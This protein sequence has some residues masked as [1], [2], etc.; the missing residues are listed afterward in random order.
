M[1]RV[2]IVGLFFLALMYTTYLGRALVVP[3]L[4]AVL[5]NFLLSP[6]VRWLAARR[7]PRPLSAALLLLAL[8]GIVGGSSLALA[9]PAAEWMGRAPQAMQKARGTLEALRLRLR[10]AQDVA[11]RIEDATT[12]GDDKA[13]A[14]VSVAGPSLGARVFGSTTALLG[15][16]LTVLFL[17]FFLLAPGDVFL[18]KLVG[19]LPTRQDKATARQISLETEQQI[20]RYMVTVT[21]VNIALA[22][23]TAGTMAVLGLPN[24]ILWGVVAGFLNFVPYVGALATLAVLFMVSLVTFDTLAQAIVPPLAFFV[25]NMIESNLLTPKVLEHWLSLNAV[26]NFVGVLFFWTIL[27]LPGALLAVPILVVCK[28]LC[29][30]VESLKPFGAFLGK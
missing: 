21:L 24:P 20:S 11:T 30:H 1:V 9:V 19:A 26:V 23:V 13:T 16:A 12:M 2:S 29:D 27:G 22:V 18:A 17:T 28:I 15:A 25:I 5:L 6:A 4:V 8:T 14:E 7:V 10:K 3:V